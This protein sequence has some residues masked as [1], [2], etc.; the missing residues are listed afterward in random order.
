MPAGGRLALIVK[1]GAQL[2]LIHVPRV[3]DLVWVQIER[4]VLGRKQDVINLVFPPHA[5]VA[6]HRVDLAWREVMNPC[7][8]RKIPF[9]QFVGLGSEFVRELAQG[10]TSNAQLAL[11][12]AFAARRERM[13][14]ARVGPHGGKGNLFVGA[15]LQ[16]ESTVRR[17]EEKDAKRAVEQ[18][19]GTPD[20]GHEVTRFF[21]AFAVGTVVGRDEDTAFLHQSDLFFVVRVEG[22]GGGGG[23]GAIGERRQRGLRGEGGHGGGHGGWR[24]A[25]GMPCWWRGQ[26]E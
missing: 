24:E 8:I 25:G 3:R 4:D 17:A 15:F 6:R 22:D 1:H 14:A 7:Q 21:A 10:G 12:L 13:R 20:V 19:V 5:L 9:C 26:D 23:A 11:F 18:C 16:Q 2:L